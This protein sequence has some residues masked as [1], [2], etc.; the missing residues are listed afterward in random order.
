M[1]HLNAANFAAAVAAARAAAAAYYHGDGNPTMTDA[2]YDQLTADI[3]ETAAAHPDWDTA[4]LLDT[5][6]A[7]T[8]SA[9][10]DTTHPTPMLSLS[11]TVALPD[12]ETF[13]APF[14]GR[15]AI[16]PKL[17]G[18]A[19]RAT[20]TDGL[21]TAVVTRGD[22]RTG[23]D[24]TTRATGITGLPARCGNS[25]FEVRGE[26]YMTD[27]DF[28]E[29]NSNRVA[30]GKT[31]YANPRNAVAGALRRD[32][33]T[34]R[35]P[36]SFAAYDISGAHFT[37]PSYTSRMAAAAIRGF[38]TALSLAAQAGL[39]G[40]NV[41]DAVNALAAARPTLGYPIDGAV[42][43]AD[44]YTDRDTAGTTGRHPKWATSYKYAADTA[45]TT[46]EA[47]E[48]SIGRTGR[49]GIRLKVAP[50]TVG[51]ATITYAAGHN[52]S[53][54]A[55][56]NI[57]VGTRVSLYRAGDVI[58]RAVALPADQQPA[59]ADAWTPPNTCPQCDQPW[60]TSSLLW[61]CHTPA[62]SLAGAIAYF[63]SRDAMD[64]EGVGD[65]VAEALAA[66]P[67]ITGPA[68][69]YT[70]SV[71]QWADLRLAGAADGS[72]RRLGEAHAATITAQ[73]E[74]SKAQPLNRVITAL[75]L[76]MTGRSV[77]RWLA[78]AYPTMDALRTATVD[79]LA[80]IDGIGDVKAAHIA[81]GL[82]TASRTIDGL[83]AA[84]VNMGADGDGQDRPAPL[85]GN[86]YAVSGSVPGY[87]RTT[88]AERIEA[89]GGKASSSVSRATTALVTDQ[90]GT[91]KARKAAELGIPIIDPADFAAMLAE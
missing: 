46:V 19:V 86:T 70:M 91:A 56:Q 69:L 49:L 77:G 65:V 82:A 28:T 11:K 21:L 43:K 14:A 75:G 3:A 66:D 16:E 64:I 67:N 62:C 87:T 1:G 9:T 30:A 55:E 6:A 34:Y 40:L 10:A 85:A 29:A 47:V 90:T 27:T 41:T 76:R 60:D 78:A 61:R 32:T 57:G 17:D 89:L 26:I 4:G 24:I 2:E 36:M 58:P 88:V 80:R 50:V 81:A 73:L 23:D 7:G 44:L 74:T 35:T 71:E 59:D 25:T 33:P 42:I 5:V 48:T 53:W 83:A 20:Y 51:G 8:T 22:G 84:G 54:M 15:I 45:T 31:G 12:L 39:D 68:D 72:T 38:G 63:C 52:P 79:D 18:M 13:A 37:Q